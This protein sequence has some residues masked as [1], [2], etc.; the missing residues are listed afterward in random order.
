MKK[1]KNFYKKKR[2]Q[3]AIYRSLL[4]F[5]LSLS[6]LFDFLSPISM[7]AAEMGENST[8]EESTETEANTEMEQNME[9]ES[10]TEINHDFETEQ[11]E[12]TEQDSQTELFLEIEKNNET[13]QI[14]KSEQ[15]LDMG[16]KSAE[17]Q[18]LEIEQNTETEQ[19]LEAEQNNKVEQILATEQSLDV[20]KESDKEQIPETENTMQSENIAQIEVLNIEVLSE[21]ETTIE[22][23]TEV[24][25]YTHTDESGNVFTYRLD[26]NGQAVIFEI[27]LSGSALIIPAELD[28]YVVATVE[29]DKSCVITNHTI[30]IPELTIACASVGANAFKSLSIGTLTLAEGIKSFSGY[31]ETATGHI[32]KQFGDC[33]IE[34][35]IVEVTDF[36]MII[37]QETTLHPDVQGIFAGS[38]IGTI[39]F[40]ENVERIP[41]FLF[42]GAILQMEELTL[43][44]PVIGAM[45]FY[46]E[47]IHIRNLILEES[48]TTFEESPYSTAVH[49]HYEQ[50]GDA[51]IDCITLLATATQLG[52]KMPTSAATDFNGPF[53]G[54][55]LGELIIGENVSVIAE[56][57]FQNVSLSMDRLELH[58][59]ELGAYAFSGTNISLGTLVIGSEIQTFAESYYSTAINHYYEQFS[60]IK[61]EN[62][63][64][65]AQSAEVSHTADKGTITTVYGMFRQADIGTLTIGEHVESLPEYLFDSAKMSLEELY[66]NV[67]EIGACAFSGADISIGTLTIGEGVE[68]FE[69]SYYSTA[70]SHEYKQFAATTIGKVCYEAK[71]TELSHVVGTSSVETVYGMFRQAKI[72]LLTIGEHVENLPEYLFESA[73][74][75][76]EE[77]YVNVKQIG[78]YA[79]S[80]A[81]ISIATL[82]IGEDV[83][84]F[85]ESYYSTTISHEYNQFAATTIDTVCYNAKSAE[86]SH[87]TGKGTTFSVYGMFQQADIE[88]I[89]IGESVEVL[90]EYLFAEAKIDLESLTLNVKEI[91]ANA[92][93]GSGISIGTLTIGENVEI[94]LESYF[95]TI[96]SHEYMQFAYTKIGI[97]RFLPTALVLTNEVAS[98]SSTSNVESPFMR[99]EITI[100][101]LSENV[102]SIP[103][104]I[105]QDA[106]M[107]L[108]SLTITAD[109][110]GASAFRSSYICIGELIIAE[111]VS[112]FVTDLSGKSL[113][114]AYN[115]IDKVFY[116]ATAAGMDSPKTGTYGPF[117]SADITTFSIGENVIFLDNYL[118]RSNAFTD[119]YVY[120]ITTNDTHKAQTFKTSYLPD[121]E[122]L[123]IHYNS[124]LKSYFING[125]EHTKW[126]CTEYLIQD[127]YG[128]VL[129]DEE[130]GTYNIEVFK[131]CSVC[132]YEVVELEEADLTYELYL[133]IPVEIALTL[134]TE[135]MTYA[136]SENIYA[137][138]RL[139]NA[140]TGIRISIDESV[141]GYGIARKGTETFDI[142]SSL[143]MDISG[144]TE[145]A[146]SSAQLQ[147]NADFIGS[148]RIE[149]CDAGE[150]QISVGAMKL[151]QN[152]IGTY[153]ISVP[154]LI[155]I[156]SSKSEGQ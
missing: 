66:V 87:V 22:E 47:N 8:V 120:A 117:R 99:S 36:E 75:S 125:A 67:R 51:E 78:A 4:C 34:T 112:A 137:Y 110:V 97:L 147:E 116:N 142:S 27:T 133:S 1:R 59:Q 91:G 98:M 140:Y 102:I 33:T 71:T 12:E 28:G 68:V 26:E 35:L 122:N 151:L 145:Y 90:P 73:E 83:E 54:A 135:H 55:E 41:S 121:S 20:E 70:T 72:G 93:S 19:S 10:D 86:L 95:S 150:L 130:T 46:G 124:E 100:L 24:V 23:S 146:C 82:T 3:G 138:G 48:V 149:E 15:S 44:V 144:S 40:D 2:Q 57:L 81:D 80:G 85:A 30:M 42:C 11:T 50:F 109:S 136:G 5:M 38:Q 61:V 154:L 56:L 152:G 74:M 60:A 105:F 43:S 96:S 31:V 39:L 143:S 153:E 17:G 88:N 52:Y 126:L 21:T 63:V 134:D 129:Y 115:T 45:A 53:Y 79:F 14:L 13:E 141:P 18:N 62:L 103:N 9:N 84:I 114:F 107:T 148:N 49:H 16:Q 37:P 111:N 123:R 76:L 139:G 127:G 25:T 7:Y 29:N 118:L 106:E 132:G 108:D 92:F 119:C 156:I 65:E 155:E 77:L 58:V 32:W 6:F 113:A 64:Y 94:F 128:D 104:Y 101:E 69:E 89:M 131:H